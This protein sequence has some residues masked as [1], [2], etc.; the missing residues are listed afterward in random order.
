MLGGGV[1]NLLFVGILTLKWK[2][3][4]INV[5][6]RLFDE[7][8]PEPEIAADITRRFGRAVSRKA[9][10]AILAR[11]HREA[12]QA[13]QDGR[14]AARDAAR[15]EVLRLAALGHMPQQIAGKAAELGISRSMIYEIIGPRKGID[16][17]SRFA[18]SIRFG[19]KSQPDSVPPD[20]LV[21]YGRT[22]MELGNDD[23]R[24]EI[25]RD[26]SGKRRYCLGKKQVGHPVW[27]CAEHY[28]LSIRKPDAAGE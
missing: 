15:I 26:V 2:P 13:A 19:R 18:R 21:D 25:G 27:Y 20:P 22:F 16:E 4:E 17:R 24:W 6:K 23:C 3:E 1:R 5:A 12:K 28:A 7:G 9:V 11:H 8:R 14:F 10:R